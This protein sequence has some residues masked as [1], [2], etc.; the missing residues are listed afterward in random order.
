MVN[1]QI[2]KVIL[3]SGA[4]NQ[5]VHYTSALQQLEDANIGTHAI[6][7]GFAVMLRLASAHRVTE[8]LDTVAWTEDGTS[9]V[10]IRILMQQG[11]TRSRNGIDLGSTHIDLIA[12]SDYD[13]AQ[14]P[15][16]PKEAMFVVS[17]SFALATATPISV[18]ALDTRHDVGARAIALVATSAA[19]VAMK[20]GAI[21]Q[22][23]GNSLHK[24][25]SDAFDIYRLLA[26]HDRNGIVATTLAAAP[27]GLGPWCAHQ[28]REIFDTGAQQTKRW[29]NN[30]APDMAAITAEQL[31]TVGTLFA[32]ALDNQLDRR[33]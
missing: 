11:A 1:P 12:V 15:D 31:R 29:L 22:R 21:N 19:L 3:L 30:G 27:D 18:E 2:P 6:V 10:P 33:A 23:R 32:D 7:G 13:P 14:L 17:H 26:E 25:S 16:D 24:R 4:D 28:A 8:D 9:D 20:L 5:L